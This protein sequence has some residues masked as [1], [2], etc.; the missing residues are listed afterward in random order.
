MPEATA[1]TGLSSDGHTIVG[2]MGGPNPDRAYRRIGA[3][4]LEDLGS[5]GYQYSR[6]FGVSGDGAVVAAWGRSISGGVR[7][8][9]AMRWTAQTGMQGL[10]WLH[11][12]IESQ[13]TAI[14]RDGNT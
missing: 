8:S 13:A 11:N 12:A 4:P 3:G 7:F 2:F 6:A 5:G 9:Q 1:A 14:S 10:G